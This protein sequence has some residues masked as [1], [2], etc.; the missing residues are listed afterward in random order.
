MAVQAI[1]IGSDA[2]NFELPGVDG[3]TYALSDFDTSALVVVFTCNHCPV[4]KAYQDRIKSLQSDYDDATV[5][6]INPNDA[7]QYPDDSFEM[8]KQ[9]AEEEAFNFPYLR[10][11][12]QSVAESYGAECTPHAFVFDA[13]RR[14]VYEGAID[15]DK[16]NPDAVDRQYVREAIDAIVAGEEPETN[17]ASPMGC[18]IK[19]KEASA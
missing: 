2:P 3:E 11:E 17:S 7:E 5:V 14:L 8:M 9:R 18:S 15:D 4:A 19:W 12:S 13:D 6:A 16:E 1:D 10:D